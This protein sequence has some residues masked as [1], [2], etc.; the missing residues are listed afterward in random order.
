MSITRDYG[1][2]IELME[3]LL[4]VYIYLLNR[5]SLLEWDAR[6]SYGRLMF[7]FIEYIATIP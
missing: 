7:V 4:I 2:A 6:C 5:H 1:S 3:S